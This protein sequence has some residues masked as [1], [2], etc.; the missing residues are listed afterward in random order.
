MRSDDRSIL[1]RWEKAAPANSTARSKPAEGGRIRTIRTTAEP[2]RGGGRNTCGGTE[3]A[4][5]T[6]QNICDTTDGM[7][8]SFGPGAATKRSATS[9]WTITTNSPT[10]P[11]RR[12]M[13]NRMGV[14]ML[15]GRLAAST[16][17]PGR[18][19]VAR[20]ASATLSS[21]SS[22]SPITS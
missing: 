14:P 20:D 3:N 12:M 16:H 5:R 17:G 2:T 15:Y 9:R 4:K 8:Y 11:S 18:S 1:R 6:S 10:L 19:S 13:S 7:P 22:R 21:T